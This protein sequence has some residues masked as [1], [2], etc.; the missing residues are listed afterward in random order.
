MTAKALSL[1]ACALA[2][3]TAAAVADAQCEGSSYKISHSPGTHHIT[4]DGAGKS[5]YNEDNNRFAFE[6]N[7]HNELSDIFCFTSRLG[8]TGFKNSYDATSFGPFIAGDLDFPISRADNIY[9]YV[10]GGVG[11]ITGYEDHL[12]E[13]IMMGG[14]LPMPV[15]GAGLRLKGAFEH[16]NSI[17]AGLEYIP[18]QEITNMMRTRNSGDSV[19]S[20]KIAVN[21]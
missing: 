15:V 19:V 17:S 12:S 14:L 6:A 18:A 21:F 5:G 20:A 8:L 7:W 11:L 4:N 16:F 10:E 2:F 3:S 13:D 1:G 9:G